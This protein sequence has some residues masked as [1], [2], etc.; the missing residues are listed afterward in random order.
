[1]LELK[2]TPSECRK[3]TAFDM[4]IAIK[5]FNKKNNPN[6]P[7]ADDVKRWGEL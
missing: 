6:L 2:W 7:S 5:A 1:M 4:Q 3:A